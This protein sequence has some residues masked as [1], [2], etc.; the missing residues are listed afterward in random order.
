MTILEW[1][2]LPKDQWRPAA[3]VFGWNHPDRETALEIESQLRAVESDNERMK[4][5]L[6]KIVEIGRCVP[7]PSLETDIAQ[8]ALAEESHG[9]S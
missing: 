2:R 5:A 9:I 3:A 8:E 4:K 1:M 6:E 7:D